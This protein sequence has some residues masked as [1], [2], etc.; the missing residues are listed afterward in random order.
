M[1]A[2]DD[3][4]PNSQSSTS[5]AFDDLIPQA[6]K[7]NSGIVGDIGTALK[8]GVL[9]MPGMATGLA[10]IAAA[11]VSIATG[12]NRPV[13]RAADWLGEQ[14][15]LQFGKWA[16]AA[17]AEYSPEMQQAQQNVEQAKGFLPTIGA[18]VQNPRVAA[19][20]VAESLPSTL[21]G[22][23]LARGAM[24][25]VAGAEKLTALRAAAGS[26]DA[27]VANAARRELLKS[28]AIAA[29]V[30]E[31]AVTAG[32]QMAQTG[33]DVDPALAAGAALGAGV[34]TGIIGGLSGRFAGSAL[35]RKLGLSDIETSMAAGTLGENAGKAGAA[36]YARRIGAGAI[37]EGLVEE[38]PQSYQEQVWQN[39]AAGKPLTEG[40]AEAAA[41]GAV[42]GGVMGAGFNI[43]NGPLS[44]AVAAAPGAAVP[45][46]VPVPDAGIQPQDTLNAERI[47]PEQGAAQTPAGIASAA[48]FPQ[49]TAPPQPVTGGA[50][51]EQAPTAMPVPQATQNAPAAPGSP[52]PVSAADTPLPAKQAEAAGAPIQPPQGPL[53]SA[54]QAE[55]AIPPAQGPEAA[56]LPVAAK[57][58]NGI[59][60]ALQYPQ[61]V[62]E[63]GGPLAQQAADMPLGRFGERGENVENGNPAGKTGIPLETA[64]KI[65]GNPAFPADISPDIHAKKAARIASSSGIAGA[66]VTPQQPTFGGVPLEQS[67][68]A[69][70]LGEFGKRAAVASRQTPPAE[71]KSSE[72][73]GASVVFTSPSGRAKR[74]SVI[75]VTNGK[76]VV[77][78]P[79]GQNYVDLADL[80]RS[81]AE[82]TPLKGFPASDNSPGNVK[83]LDYARQELEQGSPHWYVANALADDVLGDNSKLTSAA[84][85]YVRDADSKNLWK[86]IDS[87]AKQ[88]GEGASNNGNVRRAA[89]D[90]VARQTPTD[91]PQQPLSGAGEQQTA[92]PYKKATARSASHYRVRLKTPLGNFDVFVE[93]NKDSS[94]DDY[95][96]DAKNAF[97]A[98]S[99]MANLSGIAQISFDGNPEP[100]S[101]VSE[102][103]TVAKN[104][105]WARIA[106]VEKAATQPQ[107][108]PRQQ[109]QPAPIMRRDDL[110][111]A[112]MRVTGGDGINSNMALTIAGDTAGRGLSKLRG[113]FTNRGT[114]DLGEVATRLREDEGFDVRDG[115]H[116][117]ELIRAASFG[118]TAVSMERAERDQDTAEEKRHRDY[119]RQNAKKLKIKSVAV[120]FTDLE[121]R[122]I[123]A[124]TRRHERA[125]ELLDE[126]AKKRFDAALEE[127]YALLPED[128]V[129]AV[130]VD[131]NGRGLKTLE[132][133]K[134]A[135]KLLR[136]MV[137]DARA[138][139]EQEAL[140]AIE[141]AEPDWLK[142]DDGRGNQPA[143]GGE[144]TNR[145]AEEAGGEEYSI[146]EE[147]IFTPHPE[148]RLDSEVRGILV[149]KESTGK[150][151]FRLRI[152]TDRPSPQ[153]DGFVTLQVYSQ[154]GSVQKIGDGLNADRPA[155][156]GLAAQTPEEIAAA[157]AADKEAKQ[158]EAAAAA[159][160]ARKEKA[161]QDKAEKDR[162]AAEVL[163]ER[164]IAK[165]AEI[166]KALEDFALGQAA[167]E[168]VVKKVTTEEAKGQKDIFDAPA[169]VEQKPAAKEAINDF[170]EKLE[171][172]RKDYAAQMKDAMGVDVASEP[173]SKSWP[174][175]DYQKL[176]DG[177]A[178]PY[179]VAFVRAAR[180]ELPT[181]PQKSWKLAGWVK[182]AEMLRDM[183]QNLLSGNITVV[184]L[185][186]ILS[187]ARFG[188]VRESVG[189][190][191]ELYELV[192]HKM[193]LKGVSFAQHF[194]SLYKGQENVRK[195]VVEQKA[196]ATVFSNWPR[197]LAVGD[198]KEEALAAFKEKIASLDL[199]AGA[200]RQPQ[201]VIYRK[202]GEPGA[203]VGK[204]IGREY[205]DLHK[206]ADVAEARKYMAESL[207]ALEAKLAKYKETPLERKADNQPRVGD[208]HRN[209][210][211]VT[212]EVFSDTFGFRGVQFGNYVE[213]NRR[214]SDLNEA[215]DGLMD[216]AAV[217]GIQPRALSLNGQLGLAFG[218][219]GR[220]GKNAPAA[221]FE[222]GR[223]VIN[224]TKGGGPGSL[225]HEWWHSLDN[226]FA[227]QANKNSTEFV[228][229]GARTD[230]VREAMR[231]AFN[232]VNLAT[233]TKAYQA[234]SAELD[235]RRSKPYWNTSEERSAR[236]FEGYVIAKLFDQGAANDYLANVVSNEVW[237][238]TEDARAEL[239]GEG[240]AP[241]TYPY[242]TVDEMPAVRAAFDEFFKTVE[243]KE[244]EDGNVAL[245]SFA[246]QQSATA[247]Q[248]QL[249]RAKQLLAD[250]ANSNAV[251]QQTGWFKGV[252]GKWRYEIDDSGASL[253]AH[254]FGFGELLDA[255]GK[256]LTLAD[257][258]DHPALFAAYPSIAGSSV[259][260]IDEKSRNNG[261]L[262]KNEDGSFTIMVNAGLGEAK[263]LSTLLHEIQHGI[264]NVEGFASGGSPRTIS[265]EMTGR[266]D[267]LAKAGSALNSAITAV[268]SA[269]GNQAYRDILA[270][271]RA[272]GY[273][274]SHIAFQL[275]T[276]DD[277]LSDV[278]MLVSEIAKKKGYKELF[279]AAEA[280]SVIADNLIKPG[281][282]IDR[283][284]A[285]YEK[286][287]KLAGE[288]E[289]RNVQQRQ[290]FPADKRKYSDPLGTQDV[291]P[292][293]V[294][295][296][297]NGKDAKDAP[298][299]ANTTRAS[300][301][302]A[303]GASPADAAV[304]DMA[305]EG[306]S[307]QEILA[308][309]SKASRRPFNRVLAA[310]LSQHRR[311]FHRFH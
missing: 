31:G 198:T 254:G 157:E 80:K 246:G 236:A 271:V 201:F 138:Q 151:R 176:L 124:L 112:I 28:G 75:R 106:K 52:S 78:S 48:Q 6:P 73:V 35:G 72:W 140:D 12:V 133:W 260:A 238:I 265:A 117:S 18:V 97:A 193:S 104:A 136:Y 141:G 223:V 237:D 129:D 212:P 281:Q 58:A 99:N 114:I 11:P 211:P 146:G 220:G 145:V 148:R 26:A 259:E 110:V 142:D 221:H 43:A 40:A 180:D 64:G 62:T 103:A 94:I 15:G 243:T 181:K 85:S 155:S 235:K 206:A 274:Y 178:D 300:A 139:K 111:G 194:Y 54:D 302:A 248:F 82:S 121:Q 91:A 144:E 107:P 98:D 197:E 81:K 305:S 250:G 179:M 126:R 29:G 30:G 285:A 67:P 41:L 96:R 131:V 202:R 190:R 213:Q 210:A 307:A 217:L 208:D 60:A 199:G 108:K 164:E 66:L 27:A 289:S 306:K 159:A 168:P 134:E 154:N 149:A 69:M 7:Q 156:F 279:D 83:S 256:N 225:A 255:L 189:S 222:T 56:A 65:S 152:R 130:L 16:E 68:V 174:E 252:D 292:E 205:I 209:G 183:A 276:I 10:D 169:A 87:V 165:I 234:R 59:A 163:K 38:A 227:K 170:G 188:L 269:N 233:S 132:F 245:F 288:V 89:A 84:F 295:V 36:G 242:P 196:K 177:G 184:R 153:G 239:F 17:G 20:V 50:P 296:V 32:Q 273:R 13:S 49:F 120:K 33:Y 195:W 287:R 122:V 200:K 160:E 101:D 119:I 186:E 4:I 61:Q 127:S 9:Q 77:V 135:T 230:G 37:Q 286:Y 278:A 166:D 226:Y 290:N 70:P 76:A 44:K 214:Q 86:L 294:I 150:G 266:S 137:A 53:P 14:T 92:P 299:P 95:K 74:G 8:R 219:R 258:L 1:G 304:F 3:L 267:D 308:F 42:A 21:A 241:K 90:F 275:G 2:F 24:G 284:K 192:G 218:A 264:Q 47:S 125:V 268:R 182:Q 118:D 55:I 93:K 257:V 191:A 115:E 272:D 247:D 57:P 204:K 116:L 173:L 171:G 224:L 105:K 45:P 5:G 63:G 109:P 147:V 128:V 23:L 240:K 263:A 22:G 88:L 162:R 79:V 71:P 143:G 251:R 232:A 231:L 310:A 172:A 262:S 309:L 102:M 185:K 244:G 216:L 283:D 291:A 261:Q 207:P 280:Y 175:P 123:A 158:A 282:G 253:K 113:L 167:P 187:E 229:A 277:D 215:F 203:W 303:V 25:A 34:G 311:V 100:V 228:T 249:D 19:Q 297:F 39:R 293:D 51:L 298:A 301:M 46:A 270:A 161:A